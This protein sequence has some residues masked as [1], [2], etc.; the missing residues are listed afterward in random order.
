MPERVEP[1]ALFMCALRSF[2]GAGGNRTGHLEKWVSGSGGLT[3]IL[4]VLVIRLAY[5]GRRRTLGSR[6]GLYCRGSPL[7]LSTPSSALSGQ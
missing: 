6:N 3:G 1:A 4:G 7:Q 5:L 2:A